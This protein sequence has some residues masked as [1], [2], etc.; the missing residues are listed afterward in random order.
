M[1][2]LP[3]SNLLEH[4]PIKLDLVGLSH[5][6][7]PRVFARTKSW[8][9]SKARRLYF[10]VQTKSKIKSFNKRQAAEPRRTGWDR[11]ARLHVALAKMGHQARQHVR[12][13]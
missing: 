6:L 11:V 8:P 2:E 9:S 13:A 12:F 5:V 3:V 4:D 7:D 10:L 1:A